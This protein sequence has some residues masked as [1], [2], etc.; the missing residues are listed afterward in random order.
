MVSKRELERGTKVEMEHTSIKNFARK[1]ALDHLKEDPNYYKKLY[2]MEGNR[3]KRVS[4][5][6]NGKQ[7]SFLA[8]KK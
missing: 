8:R 4:F 2:K 7:V 3:R 1:I 6:T 5:T